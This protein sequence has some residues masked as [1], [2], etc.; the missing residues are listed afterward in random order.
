M[1]SCVRT[2]PRSDGENVGIKEANPLLVVT[3]I[4]ITLRDH[5]CSESSTFLIRLPTS[6]PCQIRRFPLF[7]RLDSSPLL[8][9]FQQGSA[10]QCEN[11]HSLIYEGRSSWF[12][13][14]LSN[15]GGMPSFFGLAHHGVRWIGIWKRKRLPGRLA[16]SAHATR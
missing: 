12:F 9:L 8:R 11:I 6:S 5:A 7:L 15:N 2:R 14:Y 3:Y 10:P 1:F 4:I 16:E 13:V